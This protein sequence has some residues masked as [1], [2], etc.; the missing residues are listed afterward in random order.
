MN[1]EEKLQYLLRRGWQPFGDGTFKIDG[2][3][4]IYTTN[5][6]YSIQRSA[7]IVKWR[8]KKHGTKRKG[9]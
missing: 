9:R 2:E 3:P 8:N 5:A 4:A 7:E 6:A 1:E